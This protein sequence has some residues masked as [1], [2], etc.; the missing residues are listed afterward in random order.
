MALYPRV[1]EKA[2]RELDMVLGSGVMPTIGDRDRLPYI[3]NI[4][5]EVLRWRPVLPTG[6]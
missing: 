1:Q 2:Q 5:L 6:K 3:N 4:V